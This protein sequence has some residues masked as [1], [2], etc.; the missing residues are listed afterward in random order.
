M[1]LKK[2]TEGVTEREKSTSPGPKVKTNELAEKK[3]QS[4]AQTNTR[5]VEENSNC[6]LNAEVSTLKRVFLICTNTQSAHHIIYMRFIKKNLCQF[7]IYRF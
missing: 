5:G 1:D 7:V 3:I 2:S 6:E 4:P